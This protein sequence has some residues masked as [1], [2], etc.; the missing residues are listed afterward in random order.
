MSSSYSKRVT[1]AFEVD[2][3]CT[4]ET[5]HWCVVETDY[6]CVVETDCSYALETDC[7]FGLQHE[8]WKRKHDYESTEPE[9]T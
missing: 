4:V 9:P 6:W 5:D 2:H 3:W 7:R 1:F 8:T